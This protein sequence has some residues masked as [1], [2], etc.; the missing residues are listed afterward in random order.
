MLPRFDAF[1]K[2]GLYLRN[3]SQKTARV[4]HQAANSLGSTGEP[5]SD[6][7][8]AAWIVTSRAR[9]LKA[10]SVNAYIRALN[11]YL[12]WCR[13]QGIPAPSPVKQLREPT[14]PPKLIPT[15]RVTAMLRAR[16]KTYAEWRMHALVTL[17]LDSG[18]RIDEALSLRVQ[19]VDM[20]S[21]LL[22]VTGK[23]RKTRLVPFSREA[24]QTLYRWVMQREQAA[25]RG[26]VF[27]AAKTGTAWEYQNC[28]RD[29][30]REHDVTPHMCRHTFAS[31]FIASGGEAFQL[32]RI[33]GHTDLK[34]T[35]RYVHL[36][37]ADLQRAHQA[38][39]GLKQY[40]G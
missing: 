32:Q 35:L 3:W 19:D 37:T 15:K 6:G 39:G 20:D 21:L 23:G 5:F 40:R 2:D 28:R 13:S 18:V 10:A 31:Q 29:L 17:L 34:T 27:L 33:L 11:S 8:L 1:V 7:G 22:T 9:G 26:D 12:T 4:Y 14:A 36:Q 16:P 24:R 30:K 38:F 25:V